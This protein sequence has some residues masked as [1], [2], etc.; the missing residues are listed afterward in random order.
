MRVQTG[1]FVREGRF[2]SRRMADAFIP[3]SPESQLAAEMR[4]RIR[5]GVWGERLPGVF[6]LACEFGVS[7]TLA[8]K[9]V[10]LL[11]ASKDVTEAGRRRAMRIARTDDISR[12]TGTLVVHSQAEAITSS[13]RVRLFDELS[14][15]MPQPV[16]IV[17]VDNRK[18]PGQVAAEIGASDAEI[19]L[20]LDHHSATADLLIDRGRRAIMLGGLGPTGRAPRVSVPIGPLVRAAFRRAFEAGH[21]RVIMPLWR[22]TAESDASYRTWIAAAYAEAGLSHRP[23]FDAPFVASRT[24]GS[25]RE[26]LRAIFGTTPPT[27]IVLQDSWQWFGA[28]AVLGELR[29]RVPDDVSTIM[30]A[31]MDELEAYLPEQAHFDHALPAYIR[32]VKRA[33]RAKRGGPRVFEVEPVWVPGGTLAPPKRR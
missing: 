27:A 10:A 32:Q 30:L 23:D 33:L 12:G 11:V 26:C 2:L 15:K 20:M 13:V 22:R 4:R 18:A 21:R 6:K 29:L 16:G 9:A 1:C 17:R 3:L 19:V 31:P 7:R 25:L 24:P 28:I 5:M 14:R 8:V